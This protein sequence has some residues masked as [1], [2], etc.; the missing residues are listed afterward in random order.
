MPYEPHLVSFETNDQMTPEFLSLNPEQQ[1]SAIIDPDGP[2]GKPLPLWETGA[3]PIYLAEKAGRF[4]PRMRR[5][6]TKQSSGSCGRWAASGRCSGNSASS[7]SL[8]AKD[9]EDKRPRD[10]YVAESKRLL[11]CSMAAPRHGN[12]SWATTTPSRT[13]LPSL[14]AQPDRL[15]WCR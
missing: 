12:G 15:L 7:T 4:I 14:G 3:I 10:R 5:A 11:V 8:P 1:D 9:Y 6:A 13:S 2:G